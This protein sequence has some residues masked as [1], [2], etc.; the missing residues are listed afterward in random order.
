MCCSDLEVL[1]GFRQQ[2]NNAEGGEEA[3][4]KNILVRF[5]LTGQSS[6][7]KLC[8]SSQNRA[9][10]EKYSSGTEEFTPGMFLE[11]RQ[12]NFSLHR[13]HSRISSSYNLD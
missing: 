11:R 9:V 5:V 12:G 3:V 13:K 10:E 4:E 8:S 2:G 1:F 6:V 7:S